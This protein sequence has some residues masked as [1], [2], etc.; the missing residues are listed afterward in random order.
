MGVEQSRVR[1]KFQRWGGRVWQLA[2]ERQESAKVSRSG[3]QSLIGH[4]NQPF[5][6]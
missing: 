1:E 6:I 2:R 5:L 3:S 4:E